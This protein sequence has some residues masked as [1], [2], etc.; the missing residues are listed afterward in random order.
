M[1]VLFGLAPS[2]QAEKVVDAI[3]AE[4]RK[5]SQDGVMDHEVQRVRNRRRTALAAEGESPN[6]RLGQMVD[7]MD[8]RGRLRS[9]EER[10]AA[11]DAVTV[12]RIGEYLQ[13]WSITGRGYLVSVG[14]R[15]WPGT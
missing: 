11:V 14:P 4:V 10:L 6:H 3:R 15:D 12:D 9:V 7:D 2:D 1:M 13:R 5:I 8:L